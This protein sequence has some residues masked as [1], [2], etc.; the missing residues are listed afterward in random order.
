VLIKQLIEVESKT[1]PQTP[2]I[3]L[4][5]TTDHYR[6]TRKYA[7]SFP[8]WIA[9]DSPSTA[10]GVAASDSA[11]IYVIVTPTSPYFRDPT[12]GIALLAVGESV[13]PWP[14]GTG[15]HKLGLNYAPGFL[16]QHLASN[17]GY[18][19]V[20]WLLG[21]D[22]RVTEVGAMN[23][24]LV[25]KRD[26][27]GLGFWLF[28]CFGFFFNATL[29]LMNVDLITPPL[30][31]TILPGL[32]RASTLALAEAHS[33][34]KNTLHGVPTSLKLHTHERTLMMQEIDLST[35][36]RILEVFG[37]GIAVIVAPVA[38]IGWRGKDVVLP[39][40]KQGLGPIGGGMW[41]MI[42]DC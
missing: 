35:K 37:V 13:R 3:Q 25:V 27:G 9:V 22:E 5:H 17:Q 34:G 4:V 29:Y 40:Q 33:A 21:E 39:V 26:D 2:W 31:G 14:G 24:F 15:G 19:Q 10:L 18:D 42:N 16:P 38:R 6:D 36:G 41:T 8:S 20:L 7:F 23:F 30:D 28:R 12:K 1:D 11:C 32:T